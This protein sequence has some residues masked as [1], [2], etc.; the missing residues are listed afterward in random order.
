MLMGWSARLKVTSI[1]GGKGETPGQP[2]EVLHALCR[3][4][5]LASGNNAW[6]CHA[7]PLHP[8][9]NPQG[10]SGRTALPRRSTAGRSNDPIE[11]PL[12]KP[13]EL[14]SRRSTEAS[15][16]RSRSPDSEAFNHLQAHLVAF[17]HVS[18]GRASRAIPFGRPHTGR[19]CVADDF[20]E[21]NVP[22]SSG[23]VLMQ[24][25]GFPRRAILVSICAS[26]ALTSSLRPASAISRP[27]RGAAA[28]AWFRN[29]RALAWSPCRNRK[30]P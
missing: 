2:G 27:G 26:T 20:Q 28:S 10:C 15:T 30:S 24:D 18:G 14:H 13:K 19:L 7:Q 25:H 8:Y 5:A 11:A 1:A 23:G 22:W 21:D 9:P 16:T 4:A 12:F 3:V 17:D 29:S 6:N